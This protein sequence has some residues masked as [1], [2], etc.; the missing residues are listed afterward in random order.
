MPHV[1]VKHYDLIVRDDQGVS[2]RWQGKKLRP[3]HRH[4]EPHHPH[5]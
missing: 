2:E 4:H 3:S 1:T 5:I